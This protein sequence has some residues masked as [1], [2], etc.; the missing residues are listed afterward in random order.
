MIPQNLRKGEQYYRNL[1]P[2]TRMADYP[3][4]SV[5]SIAKKKFQQITRT[6]R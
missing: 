3:N 4:R 1:R 6:G 2:L 5:F